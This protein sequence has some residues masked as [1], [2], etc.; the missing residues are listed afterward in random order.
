MYE[1]HILWLLKENNNLLIKINNELIDTIKKNNST[2]DRLQK[3]NL[4]LRKRLL[5]YE[6]R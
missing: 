3:E 6:S 2:V 4:I 1:N 5:E